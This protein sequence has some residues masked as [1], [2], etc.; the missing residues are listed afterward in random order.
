MRQGRNVDKMLGELA[1]R[2]A[3]KDK[4]KPKEKSKPAPPVPGGGSGFKSTS[5]FAKVD[6]SESRFASAVS[7]QPAQERGAI[8]APLEGTVC[9]VGGVIEVLKAKYG[10]S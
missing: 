7:A 3:G 8:A 1:E 9:G 6:R 2:A 4:P 5:L 10:C